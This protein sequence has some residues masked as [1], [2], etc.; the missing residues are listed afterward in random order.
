MLKNLFFSISLH[1]D[2][3]ICNDVWLNF[4]RHTN[5]QTLIRHHSDHHPL[6][7]S[8][9]SSDVNI[10]VP[11]KFFKTWTSHEDCRQLVSE[12]WLKHVRGFGMERLQLKL[13]SL[14]HVFKQ[15]NRTI[16]GDVERKVWLAVDEVNRI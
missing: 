7:L 13:K 6:L 8:V 5:Y 15:W 14:K 16:F 11:F 2:R 12:N 3:A 1:L 4:W 9:D 10:V